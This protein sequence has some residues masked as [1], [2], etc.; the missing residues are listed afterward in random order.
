[1]PVITDNL[2]M[3]LKQ[4]K[5][6]LGRFIVRDSNL[7]GFVVLVS[8]KR[9]TFALQK[10]RKHQTI[11]VHPLI[12]ADRARTIALDLM[13]GQ[14]TATAQKPILIEPLPSDSTTTG[15]TLRQLVTRY[16]ESRKLTETTKRD[17]KSQIERGLFD[18]MDRPADALTADMFEGVYREILEQGKET[19]ARILGRYVRAVYRWAE[20]SDPTTKLY[21][22][23]GE[24]LGKV[25]PKDRRLEPHQLPDF[26]RIMPQLTDEQQLSIMTALVTGMRKSELQSV[27]YSSLCHQTQS[28]KLA[29]TKNGKAHSLPIPEKL[30]RQLVE[31]SNGKPSDAPLLAITDKLPKAFTKSIPLSWHDCRRSTASTLHALGHSEGLI[32]SVLNHSTAGNVTQ[33][34]YLR[35]DREQIRQALS[36]LYDY[37]DY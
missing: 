27:S 37:F 15:E 14:P 35:F 7:I 6:S 23:T 29:K 11:G 12:T 22:R 4:P 3:R 19:K 9:I 33:A 18:Y 26:K 31:G 24:S 17:M 21:Q 20:L 2:I 34:H 5:T 10:G 1:M 8:S 28:I 13:R 36:M 25:T 16:T 32:K 30:W